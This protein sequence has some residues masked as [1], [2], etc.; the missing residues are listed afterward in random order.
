MNNLLDLTN[1]PDKGAISQ[2]NFEAL[3][4]SPAFELNPTQVAGVATTL[5]GHPDSGTHYE[6]EL[7]VD[8]LCARW[9]CTTA[10]TPG[11]WQQITPAF[12]ASDPGGAPDNYWIRRTD[13][14]FAEY[15]YD[16][17]G[18]TWTAI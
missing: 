1:A 2:T 8:S 10:G 18:T 13:L 17:G 9:R 4:A 6:G 16:L 14:H 7:W 11:D 5:I 3:D 15:Y 12:V